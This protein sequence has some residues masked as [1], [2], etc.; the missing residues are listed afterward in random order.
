MTVNLLAALCRHEAMPHIAHV[1]I[2]DRG[3][4]VEGLADEAGG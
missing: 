3:T 4:I 2:R 1:Q